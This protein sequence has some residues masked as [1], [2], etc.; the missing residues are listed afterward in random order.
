MIRELLLK[1]SKE[2]CEFFISFVKSVFTHTKKNSCS[3]IN[4]GLHAGPPPGLW[5]DQSTHRASPPASKQ[6]CF[7]LTQGTRKPGHGII[8]AGDEGYIHLPQH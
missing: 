5:E 4:S 1:V 8:G 7:L 6:L 3:L 2:R